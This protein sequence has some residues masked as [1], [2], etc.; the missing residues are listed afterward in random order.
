MKK[1]FKILCASMIIGLLCKQSFAQQNH[2]LYIQADDKQIFSVNINGK[3]FNS[4]D[5]GYVIIPKLTDGKYQLNISFPDNKYPDQQF[6]CVINKTDVGYALKNFDEKGWGLFNFQTLKVTMAGADVPDIPKDTTNPNA[7]GE[8]LSDVMSDTS[9]KKAGI[10][11]QEAE[12]QKQI[13]A[14]D[15][16]N[17]PSIV[18]VPTLNDSLLSA[19]KQDTNSAANKS[20]MR[21]SEHKTTAG[22]N[23]IF[24]DAS[25]G[26]TIKVFLPKAAEKEI[27]KEQ[28]AEDKTATDTIVANTN[29]NIADSNVT[30]KT[31]VDSNTVAAT[32]TVTSNPSESKQPPAEVKNENVNPAHEVVVT[33]NGTNQPN[34]PFYGGEKKA[35]TTHIISGDTTQTTSSSNNPSSTAAVKEDCKKMLADND[36]DKLRKKMVSSSTD[37]KMVQ[38]AKKYIADKCVTTDQVKSLGLLFLTDDGRYNFFDAMYKNVYDT[39]A[40]SSLQ[41]QLIDPYYKKR[42]LAM[43][44]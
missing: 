37:E 19:Q 28:K 31:K 13:E 44:K 24:I 36:L 17:L 3:T 7:F 5:I 12:K 30:E 15:G 18:I 32:A 43:L 29:N 23:M 33:A 42:F 41:S 10:E 35:D 14:E 40:F 4:S 1:I 39:S 27:A 21:V 9:L 6:S 26:D 16:T 38:T 22:T 20:I 11:L 34:N 25:T 8:M 2:F